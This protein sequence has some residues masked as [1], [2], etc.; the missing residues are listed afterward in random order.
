MGAEAKNEIGELEKGEVEPGLGITGEK[1]GEESES[2][3]ETETHL[4][5]NDKFIKAEEDQGGPDGHMNG[6]IPLEPGD[7]ETGKN[8]GDGAKNR[9]KGVE[10]EVP[11]IEISKDGS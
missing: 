10:L 7:K 5:L 1:L 8:P 6:G 3:N 9:S 2:E 4:V 11:K